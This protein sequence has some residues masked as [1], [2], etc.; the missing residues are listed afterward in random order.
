MPST[1]FRMAA[2][3]AASSRSSAVRFVSTAQKATANNRNMAVLAGAAG[4]V[5]AVAALRQQ[6]ANKTQNF[7][8]SAKTAVKETEEKFGTYWPRNIMILL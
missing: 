6:E 8:K 1:A 7:W 2:R 5:G 3:K 4:L